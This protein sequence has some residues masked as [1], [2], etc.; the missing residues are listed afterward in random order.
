YN[1]DHKHT[2]TIYKKHSWSDRS[3]NVVDL[4]S[5]LG[6]AVRI[7]KLELLTASYRFDLPR[8]DQTL[9]PIGECAIEFVVRKQ[10]P[11]EVETGK[12]QRANTQPPPDL[13]AHYNQYI[14]DINRIKQLNTKF[15]PFKNENDL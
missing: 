1:S 14:D 5:N 11:Y 13:R 3:I 12:M 7:E 10:L 8:L 4:L 2:F 15:P 6:Q 9:T